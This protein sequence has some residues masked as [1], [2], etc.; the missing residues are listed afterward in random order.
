M[1]LGYKLRLERPTLRIS[2]NESAPQVYRKRVYLDDSWNAPDDVG[3]SQPNAVRP[4]ATA[5]NMFWWYLSFQAR[6]WVR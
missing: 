4:I 3:K 5:S 2:C 6:S 1:P